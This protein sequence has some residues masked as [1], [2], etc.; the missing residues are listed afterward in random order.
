MEN[1]CSKESIREMILKNENI[2]SFISNP[3]W[4]IDV[5]FMGEP[6]RITKEDVGVK[7]YFHLPYSTDVD[8]SRIGTLNVRHTSS[9]KASTGVLINT[10]Q[11]GGFL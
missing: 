4:Y 11:H 10:C 2:Q 6:I 3:T 9:N 7:Y 5:S 1:N 8:Y